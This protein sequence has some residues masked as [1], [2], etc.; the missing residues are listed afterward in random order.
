MSRYQERHT[1]TVVGAEMLQKALSELD[2]AAINRVR[3]AIAESATEILSEAKSRVASKTGQTRRSIKAKYKNDGLLAEIGTNWY[4]A[5][6]LEFGTKASIA[7]P[8]VKGGKKALT[9]G[10]NIR[11]KA[12]IPAMPARPFLNPAFEFVRPRYLGRLEV[13]LRQAGDDVSTA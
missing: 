3:E 13:A 10:D 8:R 7:K 11:R 5:R 12:N 4:V 2:A 1:V 6:F 9:I